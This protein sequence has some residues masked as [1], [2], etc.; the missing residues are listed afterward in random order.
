MSLTRGRRVVTNGSGRQTSMAASPSRAVI[1]PVDHA[2]AEPC[3][4]ARHHRAAHHLVEDGIAGRHAAGD[5]QVLDGVAGQPQEAEGAGASRV[6]RRQPAHQPERLDRDIEDV[7]QRARRQGGDDGNPLG[8]GDHQGARLRVDGAQ[9]L[10]FGE[11]DQVPAVD[12]LVHVGGERRAAAGG[13]RARRVE[14]DQGPAD[15]Q[16]RLAVVGVGGLLPVD[17]QVLDPGDAAERDA[18]LEGEAE[19]ADG[20]HRGKRR[21]D[22]AEPGRAGEQIRDQLVDGEADAEAHEASE[23]DGEQRAQRPAAPGAGGRVVAGDEVALAGD[24]LEAGFRFGLEGG[25][26]RGDFGLLHA[27]GGGTAGPAHA[28]RSPIRN[29]KTRSSRMWGSDRVAPLAVVSSRGG[30]KRRKA[31]APASP[32]SVRS[33]ERGSDGRSP[34]NSAISVSPS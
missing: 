10:A 27:E 28:R 15:P 34:G 16:G 1:S 6:E 33:T 12:D 4:E 17:P 22:P 23:P 8:R 18:F 14:R 25:R 11:P 21:R 3:G 24:F 2:L 20:G 7:D 19:R 26:R 13:G 29:C 31:S 30:R 9:D 5:G 32:L